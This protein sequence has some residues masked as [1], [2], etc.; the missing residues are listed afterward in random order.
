MTWLTPKELAAEEANL[1]LPYDRLKQNALSPRQEVTVK[2]RLI[3]N[4][5]VLEKPPGKVRA[6][7]FASP[8]LNSLRALQDEKRN[9]FLLY[10]WLRQE[11]PFRIYDSVEVNW[12]HL[13]DSRIGRSQIFFFAGQ[14]LS[15]NEF[16]TYLGVL[17]EV[18][19]D[20]LKSAGDTLKEGIVSAIRKSTPEAIR[21]R[22]PQSAKAK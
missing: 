8:G 2:Q 19:I 6:F 13:M 16:W 10:G 22:A 14:T 20:S 15:C 1:R 4:L 18:V 17:Y 7:R 12:T 3:C 11:K 5:L 21:Q 9:L